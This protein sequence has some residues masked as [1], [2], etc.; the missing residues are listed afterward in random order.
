[1]TPKLVVRNVEVEKH[2]MTY[3]PQPIPST[4]EQE[5]GLFISYPSEKDPGIVRS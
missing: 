2:W 1:M 4:Q 5:F 3:L